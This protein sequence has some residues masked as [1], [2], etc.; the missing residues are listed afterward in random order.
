MWVVVGVMLVPLYW[1]LVSSLTPESRLFGT[2]SL[3]PGRLV[4]R[5]LSRPLRGARLLDPD[6]Q[7]AGRRRTDDAAVGHARCRR[8]P[9][10]SRGMAFPGKTVTLALVL[11][12]SMFPQISIV[13]PLYLVLREL[14]LL[15]TY[16]RPGAALHDLRDAAHHLAAGRL[17]PAAAGG[18]RGSG[19]HGRRRP[20]PH[21]L[22][23]RAPALRAR[24]GDGRDP[25]VPLQLE[26]VPVCACPSRWARALHGAGGHRAVPRTV[27]G[28]LG[29]DPCG[30]HG[31]LR[32][33]RG[34]RPRRAA[35]HR[36]RG[37]PPAR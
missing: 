16:P 24:T 19:V 37:S 2:P 11:A 21:H 34:D 25:D 29:R 4:L 10:R 27:S 28:A 31:G 5:S 20:A 36:R 26:R 23:G 1:A 22:G 32:P 30:G 13:S 7:L 35:A 6:P 9:T 15:N 33:G 18:S 12:V 14:G 3:L 17:L 8:A